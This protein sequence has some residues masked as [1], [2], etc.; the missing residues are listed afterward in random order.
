MIVG[1]GVLDGPAEKDKRIDSEGRIRMTLSDSPL[2]YAM[3]SLKL[4]GD[5][6]GR[7][8]G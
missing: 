8:Y 2:L 1:A 6:K 5:R 3:G 4:P 7:P